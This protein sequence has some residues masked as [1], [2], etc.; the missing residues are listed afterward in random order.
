MHFRYHYNLL[1]AG[2][3]FRYSWRKEEAVSYQLSALSYHVGVFLQ[4]AEGK[5]F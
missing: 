4:T 3:L 2:V 1:C 5:G